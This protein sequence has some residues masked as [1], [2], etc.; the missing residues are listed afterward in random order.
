MI[1]YLVVLVFLASPALSGSE[2][3]YLE[4]HCF[5]IKNYVLAD[6]TTVDCL[7]PTHAIKFEY[8]YKWK[9]AL[10]QTLYYNWKSG[11]RGGIVLIYK[12]LT[13][14]MYFNQLVTNIEF[15]KLPIDVWRQPSD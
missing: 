11:K 5:G 12:K 3:R 4:E 9:E 10:G 1:K 8:A 2:S 14:E 7:T 6:R 15:Y 13:D